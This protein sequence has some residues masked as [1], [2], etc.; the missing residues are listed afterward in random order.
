MVIVVTEVEDQKMRK[1]L[2]FINFFNLLCKR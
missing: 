1:K 2:Q